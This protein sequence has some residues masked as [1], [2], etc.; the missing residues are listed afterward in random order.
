MTISMNQKPDPVSSTARM[1]FPESIPSKPK[2]TWVETTKPST[3]VVKV[4][5]TIDSVPQNFLQLIALTVTQRCPSMPR[6]LGMHSATMGFLPGFIALIDDIVAFANV[7]N[8]EQRRTVSLKIAKGCCCMVSRMIKFMLKVASFFSHHPFKA[9]VVAS[10]LKL[11]SGGL[12]I[13]SSF[14]TNYLSY[15][16]N[17]KK[18]YETTQKIETLQ[19]ER[20]ECW[21]ELKQRC[22]G[23][24]SSTT[25]E[26]DFDVRKKIFLL[27]LE[28]TSLEK[29]R[30]T[31][32][33]T[34]YVDLTLGIIGVTLFFV[35]LF[36]SFPYVSIL[37]IVC[38]LFFAWR[39]MFS[40]MDD[41]KNHYSTAR[42]NICNGVLL[43]LS[44]GIAAAF[45]VLSI[46]SGGGVV[47]ITVSLIFGL[48]WLITYLGSLFT[49][50]HNWRIASTMAKEAQAA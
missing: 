21:K 25:T 30:Q 46:L 12:V 49:Y 31:E 15:K 13:V 40:D 39:G 24:T 48:I 32:E 17:K 29:K 37:S 5:S 11:L 14:V 2:S 43:T 8:L 7:Q 10:C 33:R 45:I 18:V 16:S 28:V 3:T 42:L 36:V 4:L 22:E 6:G 20:D 9:A 35:G 34:V 19:K 50:V 1:D 38:A 41:L 27:E 47:S 26:T 44:I 23:P